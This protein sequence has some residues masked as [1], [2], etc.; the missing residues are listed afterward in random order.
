[1]ETPGH[2]TTPTAAS[3]GV[4]VVRVRKSAEPKPSSATIHAETTT[5]RRVPRSSAASA[6]SSR[7]APNQ[8]G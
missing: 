1:M 2:G 8:Y 4:T 5:R 6:V 7:P 3:I